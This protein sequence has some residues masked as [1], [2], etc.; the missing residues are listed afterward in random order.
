MVFLLKCTG[1]PLALKKKMY[2]LVIYTADCT[3]Y[4]N[5]LLLIYMFR[6]MCFSSNSLLIRRTRNRHLWH[7]LHISNH[8]RN[9]NRNNSSTS[10]RGRR[11]QHRRL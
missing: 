1:V 9:S 4:I 6:T 7:Q 3:N 2:G 11:D 8:N 5:N 10:N